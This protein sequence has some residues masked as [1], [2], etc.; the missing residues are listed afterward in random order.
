M[1][2]WIRKP[3]NGFHELKFGYRIIKLYPKKRDYKKAMKEVHKPIL[4]ISH[5]L[6]SGITEI[7]ML[8]NKGHKIKP[9]RLK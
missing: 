2:I 9:L 8:P 5:I 7:I 6:E 3:S 4:C 1:N